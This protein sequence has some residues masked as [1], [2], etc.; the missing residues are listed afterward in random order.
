THGLLGG[1]LRAIEELLP[2]ATDELIALGVPS[3]DILGNVRFCPSGVRFRRV[4]VGQRLLGPSRPYL[5]SYLRHRVRELPGVRILDGTDI[6]GLASDGRGRVTGA[7]VHP[8][9]GGPSVLDADLTVDA[10][11]RGSRMPLWLDALDFPRPP[12]ERIRVEITYTT[13]QYR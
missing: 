5:E 8:A 12:E 4:D 3:G 13:R 7:H 2:G 1:G 9:A 10:T 6:V 11:G